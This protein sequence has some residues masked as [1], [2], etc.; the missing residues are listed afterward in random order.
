MIV[1]ISDVWQDATAY[2]LDFLNT[3]IEAGLESLGA[4]FIDRMVYG[5]LIENRVLIT[6]G[7]PS[8]IASSISR[9][10]NLFGYGIL[11]SCAAEKLKTIFDYTAFSKKT[12]KPWT[13]YHLCN[14]AQYK[15]CCYCHMVSTGTCLPDEETQGYRPPIDH[16]YTKSDYPFLALTLSN[17]IPCCE[18]CNG[19]QMK[20]DLDFAKVLHLNPLVDKETI[21]FELQPIASE[22]L[23]AEAYT[24]SLK[25]SDYKLALST[26]ENHAASLA[27]IAT[28]Q[29]RSRYG[30][31]ST[32]A[33]YLARKMRGIA[34]RLTMLN[35]E[36]DIDFTLD[37]CL[38]FEPRD[39]KHVPYGK[40]RLCIAKQF[41]AWS[42]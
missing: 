23:L 21:V 33:F 13:A 8:E 16:Y 19:S 5:F 37:E 3:Q 15:V 41:G 22:N 6:E 39:Y 26:T 10:E 31:Y 36:L 30:E 20:H 32:T 24:L 38:E 1:N 14:T 4:S 25:P 2:H 35:A 29:L 11:R 42:D 28:F 7:T 34:A 12:N 9:Y 27:S 18:K 40:A 17:L